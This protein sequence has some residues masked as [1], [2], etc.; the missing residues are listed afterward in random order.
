[1]VPFL[2]TLLI[3]RVEWG[4]PNADAS[5]LKVMKTYSPYHNIRQ[6]LDNVPAL[7]VSSGLHDSR[8]PFWEPLKF[9]AKMRTSQQ[10]ANATRNIVMRVSDSG[11]FEA[12]NVET[13]SEWLAFVLFNN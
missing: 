11:H 1:M 5:I 8:V 7:Y 13:T 10:A 3:S 9:V 2:H 12:S 4:N 6:M